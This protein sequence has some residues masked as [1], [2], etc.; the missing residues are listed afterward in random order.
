MTYVPLGKFDSALHELLYSL[1]CHMDW[2]QDHDGTVDGFGFY[3]W[4][5]TIEGELSPQELEDVKR[6]CERIDADD[7]ELPTQI[8]GNWI[9][10]TDERGFV[11]CT[12]FETEEELDAAWQ[13]FETAYAEWCE[14]DS[15]GE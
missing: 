15:D 6:E 3:Q 5:M 1:A 14:E 7:T 8:F 4:R 2:A 11:Y 9:V 13:R 12:A 10:T